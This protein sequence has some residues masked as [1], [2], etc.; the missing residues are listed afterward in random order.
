VIYDERAHAWCV[1][2]QSAPPDAVNGAA[3]LVTP[4]EPLIA[5]T[6]WTW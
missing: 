2:P 5:T 4:D 1:E 3:D 6:T